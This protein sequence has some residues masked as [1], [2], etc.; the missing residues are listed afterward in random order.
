VT[1]SPSEGRAAGVARLALFA[2]AA[3]LVLGAPACTRPRA[4]LAMDAAARPGVAPSTW[5]VAA[6]GLCPKLAIMQSA[7]KTVLVFG[8]TG[9]T[10]HDWAAGE[11]LAAAQSLAEVRGGGVYH[12]P[13]LLRGLPRDASGWV[14]G[15]LT[16]GGASRAWLVRASTRYG[17]R[18]AG[19][20]FEREERAYG[21]TGAGW[22]PAPTDGDGQRRVP[23]GLEEPPSA[24][25]CAA[26][27]EGLTFVRLASYALPSGELFVAGRCRDAGPVNRRD[28]ALV[29]VSRPAGEDGRWRAEDAPGATALDAI[30]DATLFA[31]DANDAYL[32]AFEPFKTTDERRPYLAHW[33]GRAWRTVSTPAKSGIT[34]LAGAPDRTLYVAAGRDLHVRDARLAWSIVGLPPLAFT[35][36]AR[37]ASLR[38]TGVHV[39]AGGEVWV[40]GGFLVR[41]GGQEPARASVLFRSPAPATTLWCDARQ[42]AE[43]ALAVVP[44]RGA[45]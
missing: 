36:P 38:I 23:G 42:P 40:E 19:A 44:P 21:W 5:G 12:D 2:G 7:G 26:H 16:L 33:D 30:V 41:D 25:A 37:P 31:F 15:E 14:T 43:G 28:A 35:E 39:G 24:I 29:V 45:P 1:L 6:E 20:L 27:G 11:T 32:A 13:A 18:A 10:P 17:V 34:A 3:A 4:P 22:Q 9:Y 8:E